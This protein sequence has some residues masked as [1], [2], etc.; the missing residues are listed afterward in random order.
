[1]SRK[2]NVVLAT[3]KPL[4]QVA[5][6]VEINNPED[7]FILASALVRRR[8]VDVDD[9]TEIAEDLDIAMAT[10]EELLK[11]VELY[12][13]ARCADQPINR[14]FDP[15]KLLPLVVERSA[16]IRADLIGRAILQLSQRDRGWK[17]FVARVVTKYPIAANTDKQILLPGS[18]AG[19]ANDRKRMIQYCSGVVRLIGELGLDDL[20]ARVVGFEVTTESMERIQ[21][22]ALRLGLALEPEPKKAG[23]RITRPHNV[24]SAAARKQVGI[25]VVRRVDS[26]ERRVDAAN[27]WLV[28]G[29]FDAVMRMGALIAPWRLAQPNFLDP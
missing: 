2:P 4:P 9:L 28:D 15:A 19:T 23:P 29:A 26:N 5:A 11:A 8:L 10:A 16:L 18:E 14:K 6:R 20:N 24:K 3:K 13:D 22:L 1:M 27:E 21:E 17:E 12:F 7:W 25:E